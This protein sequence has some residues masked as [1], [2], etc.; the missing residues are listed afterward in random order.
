MLKPTSDNLIAAIVIVVTILVIIFLIVPEKMKWK[1][2]IQ[3]A[4]HLIVN[5]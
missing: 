1:N 4:C 2:R 5:R 3:I